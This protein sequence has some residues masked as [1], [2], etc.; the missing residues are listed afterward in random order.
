MP[1]PRPV[2]CAG[3]GRGGT[4]PRRQGRR[5]DGVEAALARGETPE[6]LEGLGLAGWR[7]DLADIVFDSSERAYRLYR[8]RGD[9]RSAARLAV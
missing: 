2:E 1:E 8:D 4:R 9:R 5:A 3:R 6:A 7:L